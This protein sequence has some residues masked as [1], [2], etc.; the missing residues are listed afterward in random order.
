[1][2]ALRRAYGAGPLHLAGVLATF[3]VAGYALTRVLGQGG[4]VSVAQW[5][6]ACLLAHDFVLWPLYTLADRALLRARRGRGAGPAG[7]AGPA[8]T[9][10]WVNHVRAPAVISG[11]LLLAFFPLV[12]GLSGPLYYSTTGFG[13][14]V[15]VFNWLW[16]TAVLFA[17][18]ALI[19]LA[20]VALARKSASRRPAADES[21]NVA[22][23]A[24]DGGTVVVDRPA[25]E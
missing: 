24:A 15:Y 16:V 20:R 21:A 9:V 5:S 8:G 22:G 6:I 14:G 3:V 1:M 10:P 19:Y 18:S 23:G 11:V 4:W 7:P 12:L 2:R 13:E 17:A 25:A